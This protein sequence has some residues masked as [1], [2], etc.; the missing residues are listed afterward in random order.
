MYAC[1]SVYSPAFG[2]RAIVTVGAPT[3]VTDRYW[4][5]DSLVCGMLFL[6]ITCQAK[7]V[8]VAEIRL[9]TQTWPETHYCAV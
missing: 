2:A 3:L 7:R 5:L 8:P 9:L 4:K 6:G 1:P